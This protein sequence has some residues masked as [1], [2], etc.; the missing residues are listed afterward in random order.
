[1][2]LTQEQLDRIQ[3]DTAGRVESVAELTQRICAV[4]APT[5]NERE[6]AE[7]VA[8]LW[9]ERG[10]NPEID[11]VNNVYVRRGNHPG[12]PVLMLLAHIDTVFPIET[13][14]TIRREGDFLYGPSIGDNS[15]S[16]AAM[17]TVLEMLDEY[18]WE[19]PVDLVAV[20]DVGEE[21]LGNL[22]G[23]RTAVERYR[24]QLGAVLV[25]DGHLGV[26]VNAGVGSQRW[27]IT[28]TG[29]GGHSFGSFGTPSAIHGLGKIIAALTTLQVPKQ[30]R[31]TYNIGVI[32]GGTSVNTIA[33]HA[34]AL[35]DLRSTDSAALLTLARQARSLI[36]HNVGEGLQVEIE[37][38]GERPAGQCR[39]DDPLLLLARQTLQWLQIEPH[40][41]ASSTDANIP[42]SLGIPSVCIGVTRGERA[43]TIDEFIQVSPLA[44]GLAQVLRL[45]MDATA[46]IASIKLSSK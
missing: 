41:W 7:F 28:V 21:G 5:G 35:L 22:R 12:A 33:A 37:V 36:E 42:I 32:E 40:V 2:P 23:A 34:S 18:G 24:D 27:R 10:Y 31:T 16:V 1:M 19:T 15:A 25:V 3:H 14:I 17:I 46:T 20:A 9:R 38:L 4:P 11:A 30:P 44:R 45:C 39:D 29:P 43:H 26:I 8:M 6:R 13:S